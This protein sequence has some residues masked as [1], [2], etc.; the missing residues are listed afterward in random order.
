MYNLYNNDITSLTY[1]GTL[2]LKTTLLVLAALLIRK[3][4]SNVETDAEAQA[5]L[6]Y[7]ND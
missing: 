3:F 6:E 1:T 2:F 5:E 4:I 7:K